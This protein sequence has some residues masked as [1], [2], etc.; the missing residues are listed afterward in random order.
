[1]RLARTRL[2]ELRSALELQDARFGNGALLEGTFHRH[3]IRLTILDESSVEIRVALDNPL[4]G[5]LR[6]V[7]RDAERPNTGLERIELSFPPLNDAYWV[8][9]DR[10][11][12]TSDFLGDPEATRALKLFFDTHGS[13]RLLT[14][15]LVLVAR[16]TE[17]EIRESLDAARDTIALARRL[18]AAS[19]PCLSQFSASED[20]WVSLSIKSE[21]ILELLSP[22][23][24]GSP[25]A[26]GT[27]GP[28]DE[29]ENTLRLA[30]RRTNATLI[31]LMWL[32]LVLG[33]FPLLAV[34]GATSDPIIVGWVLL[35]CFLG[36]PG[37]YW[38]PRPCPACATPI[39]RREADQPECPSCHLRLR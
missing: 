22:Y 31:A 24:V 32:S 3:E 7:P 19:P 10:P 20:A 37:L 2:D 4:P 6:I 5:G 35:F 21:T 23:Y 8:L 9:A 17:G 36:V 29:A 11:D 38:W 13:A 33:A 28:A 25:S 27:L 30:Y 18:E 15:E 26:P 34:G 39:K 1:M 14:G 12:E 16:H